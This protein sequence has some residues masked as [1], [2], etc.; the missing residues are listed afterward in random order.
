EGWDCNTVTHILGVRAFGTRLLCEQVMGRGLRRQSYSVG[1]DE[2]LTPEYADI[3][4][5]PFSGFPVAGLSETKGPITPKPR[6]AVRALPERLTD[7]P[8]LEVTFPR[9]TGYRFDVPAERLTAKFNATHRVVLSTQDIPTTTLNA[10]VV[11]E[12]AELTL[13]EAKKLR[14]QT[15]AF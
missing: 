3:F 11:G 12:R 15:V 9:V 10:P 14:P 13:E 7:R 2:K 5:V 6:K 4:G 8:W 1:N